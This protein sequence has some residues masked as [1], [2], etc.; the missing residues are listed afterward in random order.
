M[1]T[2]QAALY[3]IRNSDITAADAESVIRKLSEIGFHFILHILL[4]C[5]FTFSFQWCRYAFEATFLIKHHIDNGK[6]HIFNIT[7]FF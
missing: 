5:A 4:T 3:V 7:S 1:S 2:D 6:L